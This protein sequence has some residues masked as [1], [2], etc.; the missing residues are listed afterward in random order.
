MV[1]IYLFTHPTYLLW[2]LDTYLLHVPSYYSIY[3]LFTYL[4]WYLKLP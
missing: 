1:V 4:L 3:Y 2:Y